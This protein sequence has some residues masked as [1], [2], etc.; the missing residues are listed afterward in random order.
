MSG[1]L[2]KGRW[3]AFFWIAL[4]LFIPVLAQGREPLKLTLSSVLVVQEKRDG[5]VALVFKPALGVKPGDVVEWRLE[6]ENTEDRPLRQ[7]ALSIPIPKEYAYLEGSALPLSL[8]GRQ[9][10]PQF[11]YDGGK[12]YGFPPLK[13]RVRTLQNGREVEREVE[14]KPEEYTHVRWL[15]PE[16]GPKAKVL[17]KLRTVLR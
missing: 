7:V 6:V 12:T 4:G 13:R 14:V 15:L 8:G 16:L 2:A 10:L 11:S 17:L 9:I 5:Q 1:T 3:P